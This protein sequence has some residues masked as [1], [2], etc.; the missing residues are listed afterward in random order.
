M[1][2]NDEIGA[3]REISDAVH[4]TCSSVGFVRPR[5]LVLSVSRHRFMI[6]M[7]TLQHLRDGR[8]HV[9]VQEILVARRVIQSDH[10]RL[11]RRDPHAETGRRHADDCARRV[12]ADVHG[13]LEHAKT[14]NV[15]RL[16]EN[17]IR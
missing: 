9:D 14:I 6:I 5:S 11:M 3:S 2:H 15:H 10:T 17:L 1:L 4:Q 16:G 12:H 7:P 8:L 13:K